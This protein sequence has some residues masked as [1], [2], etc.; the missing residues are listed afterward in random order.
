MLCTDYELFD[1]FYNEIQFFGCKYYCLFIYLRE[2]FILIY[3]SY[4]FFQ[5]N[6][7]CAYIKSY[8]TIEDC[9][10][11]TTGKEM[12]NLSLYPVINVFR[13][14]HSKQHVQ[15]LCYVTITP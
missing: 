5:K 6:K 2:V 7:E 11:G 4:L 12:R 10:L 8:H 9:V 15:K 3:I 13:C 14:S 1:M